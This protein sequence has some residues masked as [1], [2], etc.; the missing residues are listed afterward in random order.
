[1]IDDPLHLHLLARA[2]AAGKFESR[3]IFIRDLTFDCRIGIHDYEQ[4]R[5]QKVVVNVDLFVGA[6]QGDA[7]DEI[8][9]GLDYDVVRGDIVAAVGARHFNLQETLVEKIADVCLAREEVLAVRV[10]T[11][12][13][14]VY[15]DA[16]SVGYEIIRLKDG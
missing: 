4:N 5:T 16:K 8:S 9:R 11:Q 6:A 10:S 2:G 12:K 13:T 1:M 15:P 7:G 3:R 14:E